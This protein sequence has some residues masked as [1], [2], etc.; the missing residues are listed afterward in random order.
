MPKKGMAVEN[1]YLITWRLGEAMGYLWQKEPELLQAIFAYERLRMVL[2]VPGWHSDIEL[3][4][5]LSVK[6]R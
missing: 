1:E 4:I 3:S 6:P 5:S 2:A